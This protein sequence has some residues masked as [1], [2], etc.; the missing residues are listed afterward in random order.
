M[1]PSAMAY[2]TRVTMAPPE[3]SFS[4]SLPHPNPSPLSLFFFFP[5]DNYIQNRVDFR[6]I[7]KAGGISFCLLSRPPF[8]GPHS[9]SEASATEILL[10]WP[11]TVSPPRYGKLL[12][13]YILF[14]LALPATIA[15]T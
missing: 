11:F 9:I 3:I 10:H 15:D 8:K 13:D 14:I 1:Q 6:E 12:K 2:T 4:L 5:N 7:W